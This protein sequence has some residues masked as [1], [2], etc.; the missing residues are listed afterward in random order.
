LDKLGRDAKSQEKFKGDHLYLFESEDL[1]NWK[2]VGEFYDRR[3][4]NKWT[5]ADEDISCPTFLPLPASQDG[6]AKSDKYLLS[7]VSHNNGAQAYIGT[8][9][10]KNNK[11]I[12]E[13]HHRMSWVDN[14][15][16]VPE[17]MTDDK[18][19]HILWVWLGDVPKDWRERGWSGVY[20]LPRSL[21]LGNDNTL[22]MA[23]VEEVKQLRHDERRWGDIGLTADNSTKRLDG[24][25]GDSC[26]LQFTIQPDATAKRYGVKVRTSPDGKETTLLYY[27]AERNELCMDLMQSGRDALWNPRRIERAPLMLKAGEPLTLRVFVDK[28]VIEIYANGLQA[29]CRRAYPI[30]NDSLGVILYAEGG[31]ATFT[32]VKTWEMMPTNPY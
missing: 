4:D 25:V 11:F 26:E 23:P 2:Y 21:W 13:S 29:I 15:Y 28:P 3:T 24:V 30:R 7:F 14:A 10:R 12:P 16:F 5:R 27:D 19:R 9:D 8:Y 32:G 31:G 20:G 1:R 18:G 6:S 17:G 22:R